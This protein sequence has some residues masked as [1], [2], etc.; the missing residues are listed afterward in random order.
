MY[1]ILAGNIQE[2]GVPR[3]RKKDFL[4]DSSKSTSRSSRKE[5]GK[6]E[7]MK[8][9]TDGEPGY[10]VESNDGELTYFKVGSIFR[11]VK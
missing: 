2:D 7:I 11:K 9:K 6:E 10:T 5:S 1:L 4:D 8:W 3:K